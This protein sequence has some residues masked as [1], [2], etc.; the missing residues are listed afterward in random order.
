MESTLIDSAIFI[1]LTRA[2]L[3]IAFTVVVVV[4]VRFV[5][6]QDRAKVFVS[7]G[8]QINAF[9]RL[10]TRLLFAKAFLAITEKPT[11]DGKQSMVRWD[12]ES[13]GSVHELL[14]DLE[15]ACYREDRNAMAVHGG[16]ATEDATEDESITGL[17]CFEESLQNVINAVLLNQVVAPIRYLIEKQIKK[18][19]TGAPKIKDADAVKAVDGV[20]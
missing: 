7:R 3:F 15:D 18:G 10:H 14:N 1:N 13:W 19:K 12:E 16:A 6:L 9:G 8:N 4:V 2:V 5:F 11:Y 20:L 17:Q